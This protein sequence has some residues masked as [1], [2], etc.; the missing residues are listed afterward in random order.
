MNIPEFEVSL[1]KTRMFCKSTITSPNELSVTGNMTVFG[2][3]RVGGTV[4]AD[5]I[6]GGAIFRPFIY[7]FENVDLSALW[8]RQW[9]ISPFASIV[10]SISFIRADS[11]GV[12]GTATVKFFDSHGRMASTTVTLNNVTAERLVTSATFDM[13][14][15]NDKNFAIMG[16]GT[17]AFMVVA[18]ETAAGLTVNYNIQ[19]NLWP[20]PPGGAYV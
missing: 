10:K 20:L 12:A 9:F 5:R 6:K 13:A 4:S 7:L 3:V 14:D 2:N 18:E 1:S 8:T 19:V 11:A 15:E 16:K 17:S